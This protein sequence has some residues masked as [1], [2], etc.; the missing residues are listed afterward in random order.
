[1]TKQKP[2]TRDIKP[3]CYVLDADVENPKPDRRASRDWTNAPTWKQGMRLFVRSTLYDVVNGERVYI[4]TI[5]NTT[6]RWT[7]MNIKRYEHERWNAITAYMLR[8]DEDFDFLLHRLDAGGYVRGEILRQ[9]VKMGK[10]SQDELE[11][12]HKLAM[13]DDSPADLAIKDADFT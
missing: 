5:E 7:H 10:I 4:L 6:S 12:A 9:L 11:E 3:G 2:Q 1:M 8:V 13:S